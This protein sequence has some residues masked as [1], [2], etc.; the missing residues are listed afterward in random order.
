VSAKHKKKGDQA[1]SDRWEQAATLSITLVAVAVVMALGAPDKWLTAILV[2]VGTFG[3]MISYFRERW[4]SPKF[5]AIIASALLVHLALIGLIFGVVL[6]QR[7][8]VGLLVCLPFI[9]AESFLIYHAVK[10]LGE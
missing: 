3:G 6:K 5:W 7:Y 10:F 1:R 2:T 4:F 9:L 8:D